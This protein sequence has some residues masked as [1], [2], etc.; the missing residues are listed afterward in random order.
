MAGV[1]CPKCHRKGTY[2]PKWESCTACNYQKPVESSHDIVPEAIV[3]PR[4]TVTK[5][6]TNNENVT[7]GSNASVTSNEEVTDAV[8]CSLCG[9]PNPGH[10]PKSSAE[11][12][13]KWRK[14]N[15]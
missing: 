7:K 2:S 1:S 6:V 13:K 4:V 3:T 5:P 9:C 10:K 12:Q 8:T 15:G 14:K 11:R